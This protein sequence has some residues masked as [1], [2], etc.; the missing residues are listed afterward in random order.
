MTKDEL[1]AMVERLLFSIAPDLEGERIEPEVSFR[2][3]FD[4]DSMDHLNFVVA[5][6]E[7]TGLPIPESDYPRL[8]SLA[9]CVDYLTEK[10]P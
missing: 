7:E 2:D 9:G 5:V 3:Q 6:S 4:I 1:A 8:T 10:L